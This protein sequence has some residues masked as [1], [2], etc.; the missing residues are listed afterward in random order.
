MKRIASVSAALA[1]FGTT[2]AFT[3]ACNKPKDWNCECTV[4]GNKSTSVIKDKTYKEAKAECNKS[5]SLL[6]VDY[7]CSI[8]VF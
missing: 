4:N 8:S 3:T 5:G 6:G 2:F 1:I 7:N